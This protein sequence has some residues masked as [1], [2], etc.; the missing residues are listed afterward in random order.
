M[1][2]RLQQTHAANS[3]IPRKCPAA[4]KVEAMAG[5]LCALETDINKERQRSFTSSY[6][7]RKEPKTAQDLKQGIRLVGLAFLAFHEP[8]LPSLGPFFHLVIEHC[9]TAYT[10]DPRLRQARFNVNLLPPSRFGTSPK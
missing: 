4:F 1:S 5:P 2:K 3:P 10:F 8:C 7:S 9:P 6:L